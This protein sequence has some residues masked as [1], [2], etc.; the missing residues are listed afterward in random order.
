MSMFYLP[1]LGEGLPDAEIHQWYVKV[2]DHIEQDQPLVS[3]ETAKAVVDVPAPQSGTIAELFG[4]PGDIIKTGAPLMSFTSDTQVSDQGTVVG[5]LEENTHATED[6][7][8]VGSTHQ[9]N[10]RVKATPA[11]RLLAKQ[12]NVDLTLIQG[13]GNQGL[14][15]KSDIEQA[16]QQQTPLPEGFE[17]LRGV[18]RAMLQSMIDAHQRIVPVT[19]YDE[20]DI[21]LWPKDTDLTLRLIRAMIAAC[22]AEPALNAWFDDTHFARNCV[23]DINIGL[24]IDSEAGLFVPVLHDV[25]AVSDKALRQQINEYKTAVQARTVPAESLKGSTITLSNFGKFAGRYAT[26][27]IVPPSVAILGVGRAYQGAVA[28]ENKAVIHPILPLSLTFD[29]R[30]VTGGEATRFLGACMQALSQ[31]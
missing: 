23:K 27:I 11:L 17:P 7:F 8:T 20:V 6:N 28:H 19:I 12:L 3:M 1:D 22:I 2:G 4:K 15:T 21:H 30:A 16:R 5:K 25:A 10:I 24:A 31:A 14:I 18:R 29:H 9:A 13:S 26:P